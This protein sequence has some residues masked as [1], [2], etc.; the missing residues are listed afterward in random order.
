[1]P[2]HQF[3]IDRIVLTYPDP[4][5]C[6]RPPGTADSHAPSREAGQ[7][8]YQSAGRESV[9]VVRL[10]SDPSGRGCLQL[11]VVTTT[12]DDA[13][14][15]HLERPGAGSAPTTERPHDDWLDGAADLAAY[16]PVA[17]PDASGRRRDYQAWTATKSTRGRRV[18]VGLGTAAAILAAVLML[19]SPSSP[20][21]SS[22]PVSPAAAGPTSWEQERLATQVQG[23]PLA[24]KPSAWEQERLATQVRGTP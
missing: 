1:M 24:G 21:Q 16:A 14:P 4:H 13:D 3:D 11:E 6:F 10:T 17:P 12:R 9:L 2:A 22:A 7:I 23:T 5:D 19:S 8:E 20:P 15:T 18:L